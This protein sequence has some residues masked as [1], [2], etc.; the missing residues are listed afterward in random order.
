[1]NPYTISTDCVTKEFAL[2]QDQDLDL[3]FRGYYNFLF[4]YMGVNGTM[5]QCDEAS[6]DGATCMATMHGGSHRS[7]IRV[8][9]TDYE[10]YEIMYDCQE[11]LGGAMKMEMFSVTTKDV[12]PSDETMAR[13][14][15]VV[16]EKLPQYDLD[17]AWGLVKPLQGDG[18][19]YEWQ[20]ET[21]DIYA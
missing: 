6:E 11:V 15:M 16:R 1:M 3:Y 2:N 20:Y 21:K 8:F 10:T 18:C 9:D 14:K 13:V 19:K 17:Q 4:K 12:N 7:P 5:Y